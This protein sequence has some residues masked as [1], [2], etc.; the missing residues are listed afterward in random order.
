M[1]RPDE[2]SDGNRSSYKIYWHIQ[3]GDFMRSRLALFPLAFGLLSACSQ[4]PSSP[5]PIVLEKPVNAQS[6]WCPDK[7]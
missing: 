3:T 2:S 1:T 4:T 6:P 7:H 5:E